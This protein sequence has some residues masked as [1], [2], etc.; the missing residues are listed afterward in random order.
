MGQD[1]QA[2]ADTASQRAA[3]IR[4]L[5]SAD[6][7]SDA[8]IISKLNAAAENEHVLADYTATG[9]VFDVVEVTVTAGLGALAKIPQH[10]PKTVKVLKA[11]IDGWDGV[12]KIA[13]GATAIE[14]ALDDLPNTDLKASFKG[15][16]AYQLGSNDDFYRDLRGLLTTVPA[17][18][19]QAHF[20]RLDRDIRSV[21]PANELGSWLW[22]G[23]SLATARTELIEEIANNKGE[24]FK[25]AFVK[26]VLR[27]LDEGIKEL[28][29]KAQEEKRAPAAA[30]EK[31]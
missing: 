22:S 2:I 14:K 18:V 23:T 3:T 11:V 9:F 26:E 21:N 5:W 17:A 20:A 28:R 4:Q 16:L 8:E 6:I 25:S 24:L 13:L 19:E 29:L 15:H 7:L 12:S 31:K 30:G 10:A 27:L 1:L